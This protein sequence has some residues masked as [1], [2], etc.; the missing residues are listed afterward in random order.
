M[1]MALLSCIPDQPVGQKHI[2]RPA[3]LCER[4]MDTFRDPGS[5]DLLL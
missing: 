1:L 3:H 2:R 4:K 5:G